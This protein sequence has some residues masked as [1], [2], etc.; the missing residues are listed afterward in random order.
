MVLFV[1]CFF[2]KYLVLPR[3]EFKI[4]RYARRSAV[5]IELMMERD[6]DGHEDERH[7]MKFVFQCVRVIESAPNNTASAQVHP[8]EVVVLNCRTVKTMISK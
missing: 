3:R 7:R 8:W 4:F 1:V 2:F 5:L 6:G